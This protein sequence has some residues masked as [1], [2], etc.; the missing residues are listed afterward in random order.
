MASSSPERQT[1][2]RVTNIVMTVSRENKK[3]AL[4]EIA[5][6]LHRMRLLALEAGL[7]VL[8]DLLRRVITEVW[9]D[10]HSLGVVVPGAYFR[11][12]PVPTRHIAEVRSL[13]YSLFAKRV[14]STEAIDIQVFPVEPSEPGAANWRALFFLIE[15]ATGSET[16]HSVEYLLAFEEAV[17]EAQSLV[18][19]DQHA[20][21]Q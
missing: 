8:T 3:A 10:L 9:R 6:D 16:E 19:L 11:T 2:L 1:H 17:R 15:G 4:Q 5:G 21:L 7:H 18:D 20:E 14:S 12:G 13:L